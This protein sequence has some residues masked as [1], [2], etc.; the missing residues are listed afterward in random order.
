MVLVGKDQ[1]FRRYLVV[2]Q[3]F[4]RLRP[5]LMGSGSRAMDDSS[6]VCQCL[7][8]LDRRVAIE[9]RLIAYGSSATHS[10]YHQAGCERPV[11]RSGALRSLR[12]GQAHQA[13]A[14]TDVDH[15]GEPRLPLPISE[16]LNLFE[17][18]CNTTR[19]RL[20]CWSFPTENHWILKPA[21]HRVW[22]EAVLDF[23]VRHMT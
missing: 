23:L 9:V 3:C 10:R 22:Y 15:H 4:E 12:A 18:H 20:N 14:D 1:Q 11:C 7:M 16:G 19:Y 8:W 2:L 17:K 5:S 6:R 21:E 13:L